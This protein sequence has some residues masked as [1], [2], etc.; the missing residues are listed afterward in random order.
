MKSVSSFLR[1]ARLT[2]ACATLA[3]WLGAQGAFAQ[4]QIGYVLSVEGQWEDNSGR[5]LSKGSAVT[6]G[7]VVRRKSADASNYIT[8]VDRG[9]KLIAQRHCWNA[10]ECERAVTLP[11]TNRAKS[12]MTTRFFGAVMSLWQGSPEKYVSGISRGGLGKGE[13]K[14]SESVLKN[15]DG[16]VDAS[17][18]FKE[19]KSGRYHIRLTSQTPAANDTSAPLDLK[20]V[21]WNSEKP[22]SLAVGDVKPGLYKITVTELKSGKPTPRSQ[23]AWVLIS[24]PKDFEQ[25]SAAFRE[26]EGVTEQWGASVDATSVRSFLRAS[27]EHIAAQRDAK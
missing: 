20:D 14:L 2:G 18:V 16:A 23:T 6:A 19:L 8:V 9:G 24:A 26:A 12:S 1:R 3:L 25:A 15:E 13:I 7:A 22:S 5:R 10:R 27:L 11:R 4:E 21:E 17:A